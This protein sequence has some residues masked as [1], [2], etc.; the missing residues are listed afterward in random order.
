M[1]PLEHISQELDWRESELGSFKVLL[2]RKDISAT[3]KEVLLRASWA[4][5]YAHYEGFAKTVL[6]IFFDAASKSPATCESLPLQTKLF[7]LDKVLRASR[8]LPNKDY[9]SEIE[10]FTTKH[11]KSKPNFPDVDTQSNLWP[12]VLQELLNFADIRIDSLSVHEVKLKTLVSRRN[13]IAHG[14]QELIG[15]VEY[16]STFEAAVYDV[17]YELAFRVDE[18]LGSPPYL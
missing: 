8:S 2:S 18:R 17:M 5:L 15:G 12:S 6:T 14:N 16:Y 1:S 13:N 10:T 4:M 11:Y 9:L 3:Q 7:A